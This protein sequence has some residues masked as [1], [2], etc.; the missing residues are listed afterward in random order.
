MLRR[1]ILIFHSGALGD[2]VVTWPLALALGRVFAQSR[3]IYVT[4]ASK[5]KLA[6]KALRCESIDSETGWHHLFSDPASLP[7]PI[8]KTLDNTQQAF[9]FIS[10]DGDTW[11]KNVQSIAPHINLTHITPRPDDQSTFDGHITAWIASQLPVPIRTAHHQ[12]LRSVNT[13]G[14]GYK[15]SPE[16]TFY[17][18]PGA[19]SESKRWPHFV[20]L[21]RKLVKTR[22]HVRVL[23]GEVEKERLPKEDL[24]HYAAISQI[25]EPK[26]YMELL[27]HLGIAD[28][29]VCNDTGP[30]HLA[31][32]IGTPTFCVFG[33][34]SNAARWKPLGPHVHQH[35]VTD[36]NKLTADQVQKLI[37]AT[38]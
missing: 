6:E 30:G 1:N 8:R 19:G 25:V 36:L 12:L 21:V 24:D 35:V 4:A 31:G 29:L 34:H 7:D 23:I 3:I 37:T 33:P 20:P 2:F 32:I 10:T 13:R 22:H 16:G 28:A 27:T 11:Q 9:S 17:V 18:H 38:L 5:G 14:V 15:R 26:D